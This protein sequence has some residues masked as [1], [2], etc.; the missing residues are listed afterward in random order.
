MVSK[1]DDFKKELITLIDESICSLGGKRREEGIYTFNLNK[2][3]MGWLGCGANAGK[4]KGQYYQVYPVIGVRHVELEKLVSNL[5]GE[6]YHNYIPPSMVRPV[7]YL[8]PETKAET[9]IFWKSKPVDA[10]IMSLIRSIE[11]YG[12]PF[13]E[14]HNNLDAIVDSM[15]KGMG[16]VDISLQRIPAGLYLLGRV[17]EAID[18]LEDRIEG[19]EASKYPLDDDQLLFYTNLLREMN[20]SN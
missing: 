18:F 8:M 16:L 13:M 17:D 14:T 9:W 11:I 1:M 2:E 19:E 15:M 5:S 12:M 20:A 4:S 10:T 3:V 7:G 6:K